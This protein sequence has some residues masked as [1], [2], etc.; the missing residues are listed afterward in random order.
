MQV[1]R[2]DMPKFG[3]AVLVEAVQQ[4]V[5]EQTGE[6]IYTGRLLVPSERGGVEIRVRTTRPYTG[7]LGPVTIAG[8]DVRLRRYY[9]SGRPGNASSAITLY[10]DQLT[11]TDEWP[12]LESRGIPVVLPAGMRLIAGKKSVRGDWIATAMFPPDHKYDPDG[13]T[14][15]LTVPAEPDPKIAPGSVIVAAGLVAVLSVPDREDIGRYV[16]DDL[17]LKALY[18]DTPEPARLR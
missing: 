8:D 5:A 2:I 16:K 7:D 11:G 3:P 1:I 13:R 18:L 10:C 17:R 6:L 12:T 15:E 9:R 4:K 14:V